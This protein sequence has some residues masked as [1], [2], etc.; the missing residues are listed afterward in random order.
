M[1]RSAATDARSLLALLTI[2]HL[3]VDGVCGAALECHAAALPDW[4][5]VLWLFAL[6][7]L[8]A[9]GGQWLAG[10][11]LDTCPRCRPWALPAAMAALWGGGAVPVAGSVVQVLCLGVGNC[12]FHAEGGR[13]VLLRHAGFAGP[14]VFVSSGAIGLALG[15][16]GLVGPLPFL[17]LGTAVAMGA[18]AL[19]RRE[20][21]RRAGEAPGAG[22]MGQFVSFGGSFGGSLG[23]SPPVSPTVP[24]KTRAASLVIPGVSLVLLLGCVILRGFGGGTAPGHVL[25]LPCVFAAGKALGGLCCD[26]LGYKRCILLVFA[27]GFV[28]LQG[29]GL[30]ALA[31]LAL[32]FNMTMPLTLRLAHWCAPQYPG[33]MFGLAA[34]CLLPGAFFR[35][36]FSM[37]PQ[38]ML[39][40]VFLALS[41]AGALLA[42]VGRLPRTPNLTSQTPGPGN[43][44]AA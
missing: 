18:M 13:Q 11:V 37:G 5:R 7:N 12:L 2:L 22:E 27:L 38:A 31:L 10:L 3:T 1:G 20:P 6:Y 15:L 33:L 40:L 21:L 30:P 26:A 14:G 9:F 25:L 32:A 43:A 35:Q 24:L 23:G 17:L 4:E 34:G 19:M 41:A 36:D 42:S 44:A 16:G 28:A 39:V 8:V 29:S